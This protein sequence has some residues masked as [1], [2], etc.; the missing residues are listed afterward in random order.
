MAVAFGTES[1][2]QIGDLGGCLQFYTEPVLQAGGY[3]YNQIF[4]EQLNYKVALLIT[5]TLPWF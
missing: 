3:Y 4:D 5:P 2:R 1:V